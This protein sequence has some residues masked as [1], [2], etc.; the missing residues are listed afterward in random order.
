LREKIDVEWEFKELKKTQA[1]T[2][3]KFST[4]NNFLNK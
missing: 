1:Q 3:L 2:L 4:K